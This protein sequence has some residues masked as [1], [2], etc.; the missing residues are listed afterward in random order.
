MTAVIIERRGKFMATEDLLTRIGVQ[1]W[2]FA[3]TYAETAPHEY[4]I[5]KWNIELFKDICHSIDTE[6]YEETF[7]SRPF[8][9]HNRGGFKYWHYDTVLNSCKIGNRYG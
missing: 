5:D 1:Q 8:R 9:Y 7:Y 4:I 2:K 3:D 6:G